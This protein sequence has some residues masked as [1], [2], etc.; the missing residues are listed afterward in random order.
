LIESLFQL[1]I[2]E[3]K[4]QRDNGMSGRLRYLYRAYRYRYRVDPAEMRFMCERL[5]PGD[6]AVDVGCFK[7]AYTYWMRRC[8][9]ATGSVAAFEPQP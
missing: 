8:V 3:T 5:Q 6:I 2:Q 1:K 7:A 9:G 4:D